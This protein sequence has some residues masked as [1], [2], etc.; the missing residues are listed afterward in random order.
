MKCFFFES[1]IKLIVRNGKV[2]LD[3]SRID[4]FKFP[5]TRSQLEDLSGWR[6]YL[7]NFSLCTVCPVEEKAIFWYLQ[8][9]SIHLKKTSTQKLHPKKKLWPVK[10]DH[11]IK[12]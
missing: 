10:V 6:N 2:Q 7:E 12:Y 5:V 3:P 11:L 4:S 8:N 9:I 1:E